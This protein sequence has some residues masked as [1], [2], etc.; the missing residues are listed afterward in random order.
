MGHLMNNSYRLGRT[1]PSSEVAD[2]FSDDPDALE[3]FRRLHETVTN[4]VGLEEQDFGYVVGP[5]LTFDPET[6][7]HTGEYAAAANELLKNVNRTGFEV[8]DIKNL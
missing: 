2:L 7:R 1:V 4:G 3:H 8:P 6:E 5:W